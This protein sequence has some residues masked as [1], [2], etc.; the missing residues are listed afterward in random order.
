M[1]D[2]LA[3]SKPIPA[4]RAAADAAQIAA[5]RRMTPVR[6]LELA[7]EMQRSARALMDAGLRQSQPHLSPEA[8][9]REVAHRVLHARG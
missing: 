5:Y 7:V 8:R 1:V 3:H 2:A 9:R 6:R 4:H